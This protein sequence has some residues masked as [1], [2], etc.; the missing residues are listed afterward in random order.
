MNKVLLW[1]LINQIKSL[2]KGKLVGKRVTELISN[3]VKPNKLQLVKKIQSLRES[4]IKTF[5][6][7]DEKSKRDLEKRLDWELRKG[8]FSVILIRDK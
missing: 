6:V 5:E 3:V 2:H 4:M 8:S 7:V 1:Y